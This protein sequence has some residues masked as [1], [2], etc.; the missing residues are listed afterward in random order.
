[1][2]WID[3]YQLVLLDF[4]GLLVDTEQVHYRAYQEMC[5]AHGCDLDIDFPTYCRY[6]HYSAEAFRNA[7]YRMFPQ[8]RADFPDWG[9]LYRE[10][11]AIYRRLLIEEPVELMPGADLLLEELAKSGVK[12]SV[13]THSAK[14]LVDVLRGKMKGLQSIPYW[15]TREDYERPKPYP[16]CYRKAVEKF[17][18]AGDR[19]VGFEDTPR[20]LR[21]LLPTRAQAVLIASIPYP[22]IE[23]LKAEGALHYAS[24]KGL[25]G[26]EHLH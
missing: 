18:G 9:E 3:D 17:A 2:Q 19:V 24:L 12:H 20:G 11:S 16:D 25:L 21:A 15:I 22:E 5:A 26:V 10:K 13:V 8:L 14:A 4:D 23:E 1:M 6:A 7:I